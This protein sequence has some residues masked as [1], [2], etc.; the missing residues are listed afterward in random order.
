MTAGTL[1]ER[2]FTIDG[3]N[4]EILFGVKASNYVKR[5]DASDDV[6]TLEY[7]Y[8]NTW[9]VEVNMNCDKVVNIWKRI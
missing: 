1:N 6:D 9:T 7:A 3:Q 2:D 5:T 8:E 4:A